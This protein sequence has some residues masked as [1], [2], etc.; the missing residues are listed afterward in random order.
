MQKKQFAFIPWWIIP[1]LS[2][3]NLKKEDLLSFERIRQFLSTED[4]ASLVALSRL[5]KYF[6]GNGLEYDTTHWDDR[7]V[8]PATDARSKEAI[9]NITMLAAQEPFLDETLRRICAGDNAAPISLLSIGDADVKKSDTFEVSLMGDFGVAVVINPGF[10]L[11]QHAEN[12]INL[13]R[14]MVKQLYV[15]EDYHQLMS[16]DIGEAYIESL[17]H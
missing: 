14:C 10:T 9:A 13:L 1:V 17:M 12:S 7:W 6:A 16:R 15:Y 8:A 4:L 3:N 2:R 5:T 11:L